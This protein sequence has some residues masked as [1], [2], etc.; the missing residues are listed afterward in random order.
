MSYAD[1]IPAAGLSLPVGALA[2]GVLAWWAAVVLL[3]IPPYLLPTPAAVA[4][5]L[6]ARPGL[7]LRNGAVTLRTVLAGGAVGVLAGFGAAAVAVHST[8]L[9]RALYP[10]LV[11][12]RVLPKI[13]VAPLLLVYLG[14]GAGTALSF[15]A[16]I[17]FFPTFVSSMAGLRETPEEYLDLLRSVDAGPLRTFLFV[18][19]PAALP[20]V[21]AGLKQ[22]AAL[23]AVGAVV[24]EW[25]LTDEGLGYL[26]LVGAEN[27]QTDAVLAAVVVLFVE[28][29][30]V[31]GAVAAVERRVSWK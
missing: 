11:T 10:Y 14:T 17:A 15:V 23:A 19:I 1:R 28:G 6:A 7:Y 5:R 24:A 9:R 21:F 2:V 3:G 30:A 18:R 22:S 31:Y 25:I 8:V 29:M 13:A 20:A 4:D 12:A 27:V 26:V 16:L